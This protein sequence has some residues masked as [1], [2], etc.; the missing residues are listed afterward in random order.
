MAAE[1][2]HFELPPIVADARIHVQRRRQPVHQ[3]RRT[4]GHGKSLPGQLPPQHCRWLVRPSPGPLTAWHTA[5]WVGGV[6]SGGGPEL[7][8]KLPAGIEAVLETS[9]GLKLGPEV[10]TV[11]RAVLVHRGPASKDGP[12]DR[13]GGARPSRAGLE[14][15]E[16]WSLAH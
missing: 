4:P 6:G 11:V 13:L 10:E 16:R 12:N 1:A 2:H 3:L 8:P 7:P 9:G 14:S 5:G 15:Q